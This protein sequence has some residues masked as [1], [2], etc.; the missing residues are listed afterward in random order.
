MA[1]LLFLWLVQSNS[2]PMG[3]Q[4]A[5]SLSRSILMSRCIRPHKI[6]SEP[7]FLHLI[8]PLVSSLPLVSPSAHWATIHLAGFVSPASFITMRVSPAWKSCVTSWRWGES[9]N[10]K[11]LREISPQT[12]GEAAQLLKSGERLPYLIRINRFSKDNLFW[13]YDSI[14]P[15]SVYNMYLQKQNVCQERGEGPCWRSHSLS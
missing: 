10:K 13:F 9:W 4:F 7:T 15:G 3:R 14:S 1:L 8:L 5:F 2:I 6:D 11:T 12:L